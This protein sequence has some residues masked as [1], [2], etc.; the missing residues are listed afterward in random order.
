M[1]II[2]PVDVVVQGDDGARRDMTLHLRDARATVADLATALGC[3]AAAVVVDGREIAGDTPLVSSGLRRGSLVTRRSHPWPVARR[4]PAALRWTGGVDAGRIVALATGTTVI[5]RAR[6]AHLRCGDPRVAPYHCLVRVGPAD[7]GVQPLVAQAGP[8]A[9]SRWRIGDHRAELGVVPTGAT[10]PTGPA[11]PGEWTAALHRPPRPAAAPLPPPVRAPRPVAEAA[12]SAPASGVVGALAAVVGSVV[13]AVVFGQPALLVLGGLGAAGSVGSWVIQRRSGRRAARAGRRRQRTDAA[14]FDAALGAQAGAVAAWQ[15]S[16]AIELT[17]AV[18]RA[19][20]HDARLWERRRS[21]PDH[22]DVVLGVGSVPWMPIVD[23]LPDEPSVAVITAL[24]G[25]DRLDDVPV[26]LALRAGIV[27]GLVGDLPAARAVGR[28][29]V[30]QAAVGSGPA[31]VAVS[32][33]ADADGWAWTRWLPHTVGPEVD[34]GDRTRLVVVDGQELLAA[35]TSPARTEL[36]GRRGPAA[37]IVVAPDAVALP[38]CCTHVATVDADA[39]ISLLEVATGRSIDGIVGAGASVAT[40]TSAARA[41]ARYDDPELVQPGRGLPAV[42]DLADLLGP[43]P[44]DADALAGVWRSLGTDPPLRAP[45]A[46]AADGVVD[47]DLVEHG[48]HALVAGT[49]GAGKSELLRTLVAGLAARSSPELLTFVLVDYKGGSAFDACAAL[50]HVTGVVTDLDD[51][52]AA[53]ALRSLE[54]ELRRR[55]RMLRDAGANDIGDLRRSGAGPVLPR[56]VVVVDEMAGLAAELPDFLPALVGVAQRGRSL[57]LHLVLATQRPAGVVNDDIRANTNLRVALRVQ[58]GADSHDV[59]GLPDAAALR[60]DRPGRALLRWGPGEAVAVQVAHASGSVA[61]RRS[62]VDVVATGSAPPSA[63]RDLP[64]PTTLTRLVA[65]ARAAADAMQLAPVAPPWLDPLPATLALDDLASGAVA[66]A[67]DPD[68]QAQ[69]P[70]AWTE[71]NLLCLGRAD[72]ALVSMAVTLAADAPPARR[73]LY[74]IDM[75]AGELAPL[76]GLPH[77]AGVLGA[78]ERERHVRLVRR[79]RDEIDSRRAGGGGPE[80]ILL[81]DDL[82]ALRAAFDDPSGFAVLDTLD[83]VIVDGAAVGIR[84]V[85]TADRPG[86]LPAAILAGFDRRW[87][88]RMADGPL[89]PPGRAIDSDS[90]LELQVAAV[91]RPVAD[92]CAELACRSAPGDGPRPIGVLPTAVASVDLPAPALDR[93]PWLVPIGVADSDL[94]A[95]ALALHPGDHVFIGGRSRTGRSSALVLLA[96]RFRAAD[97]ELLVAAVAL[98]SSPLQRCGAELVVT[99]AA[100]LPALGVLRG[101]RRRAVLLVDDAERV[102]DDGT[103]AALVGAAGCRVH[104]VAAGR[105]DVVRSLYGHWTAAVRRARLGVLL[106]PDVDVDGDLLGAVLPRRQPVAPVPGR[107]YLVVDGRPELVQLAAPANMDA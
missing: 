30:V 57:G 59:I 3:A 91:G 41:L 12:R 97:P 99:D 61:P 86:A 52:L 44:F 55:E 54:A 32:V 11:R 24:A 35:R 66:L 106:Q 15:W 34:A 69:H 75:G 78:G 68:H 6:D 89:L 64:E 84:V 17:A 88:F 1:E 40:A 8:D 80:I 20:T 21:H 50:P 49:T 104:V 47:I 77:G 71:G 29:L 27:L 72:G 82:P 67:D 9:R 43:G 48:P 7:A 100:G 101:S 92:V 26:T 65:A 18:E 94:G 16:Q 63:Q 42:V 83:R 25:H 46:V 2:E 38:S 53:R 102:D 28:A 107:G 73:H 90:G 13:A 37:G 23:G 87:A 60:P 95:A 5:G 19:R 33:H 10:V 51:R 58:S 76:A 85:A 79:L 22:L 103:L 31:D 96:E 45:M 93:D 62:A 56:L 70:V 4:G 98:R 105:S 39:T 81:V 74:A 14:A 36:T